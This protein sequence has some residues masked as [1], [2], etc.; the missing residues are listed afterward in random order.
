MTIAQIKINYF[1]D[2]HVK[3]DIIKSQVKTN[4][5]QYTEMRIKSK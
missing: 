2:I 1:V 3:C 4:D 5:L